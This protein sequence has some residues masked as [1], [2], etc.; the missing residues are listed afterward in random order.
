[1]NKN[2]KALEVTEVGVML[3]LSMVLFTISEFIPWPA[4]IQGGG[5]T[6]FGHVPIVVLSYRRGLKDGFA[7]SV[8]LGIFELI[9]GL[10]NFAWVKGAISYVVV[11]LFDY[12]LAFG[13]IGIGGIFRKAKGYQYIKI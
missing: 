13:I 10:S 11:A 7:A 1:M 9:M 12:I 8:L 5:V 3:A 6:L 2:S 4:W